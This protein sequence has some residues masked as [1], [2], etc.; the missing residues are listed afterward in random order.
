MSARLAFTKSFLGAPVVC[1]TAVTAIP[2]PPTSSGDVSAI[3]TADNGS[4]TEG[5]IEITAAASETITDGV[6]YAQKSGESVWFQVKE[7]DASIA[8]ES[9]KGH[10]ER[11]DHSPRADKYAISGTKGGVV[12]ITVTVRPV[13]SKGG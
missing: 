11:F 9:N 1:H 2:F 10:R 13:L 3:N 5:E 6:L 12:A 8:L 7:L 4:P